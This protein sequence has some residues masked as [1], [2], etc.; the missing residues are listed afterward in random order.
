M[1]MI[2]PAQLKCTNQIFNEHSV[3]KATNTLLEKE[4]EQYK[5]LYNEELRTDSILSDAIAQLEV[6]AYSKD[7]TVVQL[8]KKIKKWRLY[9]C[10]SI[11]VLLLIV[12]L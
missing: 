11:A 12:C 8:N 6:E 10:G 7:Q 1:I 3:L 4:I 9:G 5:E 2:T